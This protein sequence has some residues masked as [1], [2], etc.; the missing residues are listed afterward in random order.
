MVQSTLIARLNDGLQLAA[1]MDD[2]FNHL[3]EY[4]NQAKDLMKKLSQTSEQRCSID[5]NNFIFQY[6]LITKAI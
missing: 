5:S 3:V 2:D 6:F 1:S 4:K